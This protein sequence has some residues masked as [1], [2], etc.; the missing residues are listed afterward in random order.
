M[1]MLKKSNLL[2]YLGKLYFLPQLVATLYP[3]GQ[4]PYFQITIWSILN[5]DRQ[6]LLL[7][8]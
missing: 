6:N 3:K 2:T 8:L 1:F 7:S 5:K 4:Q